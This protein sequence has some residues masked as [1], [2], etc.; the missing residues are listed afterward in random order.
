[1]CVLFLFSRVLFPLPLVLFLRFCAY[2]YKSEMRA[3]SIKSVAIL[4]FPFLSML[5]CVA[6]LG[7]S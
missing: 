2:N 3:S 1:M 6:K 5:R 7:A 4:D